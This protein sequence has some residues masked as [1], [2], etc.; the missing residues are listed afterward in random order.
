MQPCVPLPQPDHE[1]PCT[2][3]TTG[4]R[5]YLL[6]HDHRRVFPSYPMPAAHA[7]TCCLQGQ[8]REGFWGRKKVH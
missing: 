3:R 6:S 4:Y 1:N 2:Q 7:W 5:E 8:R